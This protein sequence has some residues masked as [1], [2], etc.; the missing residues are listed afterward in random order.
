MG[1]KIFTYKQSRK[2]KTFS[3]EE[4][5]P[6][7]GKEVLVYTFGTD[8]EWYVGRLTESGDWVAEMGVN[9]Y[10]KDNERSGTGDLYYLSNVMAWAFLPE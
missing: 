5:L 6:Y 8:K 4:A 10:D 3:I 1:I 9:T 7:I 2:M